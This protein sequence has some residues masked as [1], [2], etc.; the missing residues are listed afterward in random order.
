MTKRRA[1]AEFAEWEKRPK[2]AFASAPASPQIKKSDRLL[3]TSGR[4]RSALTSVPATKPSWTAMEIQLTCDSESFHSELNAG[5]T[6]E[7]LNHNDM[8][9]STATDNSTRTRHLPV[10]DSDSVFSACVESEDDIR[11][12][13]MKVGS[14]ALRVKAGWTT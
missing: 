8:H 11:S 14:F 9:R 6:A 7:P 3:R 4:F 10:S 5:T 13:V 2:T 12:G 1:I